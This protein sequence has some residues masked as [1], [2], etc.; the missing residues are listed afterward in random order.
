VS[1]PLGIEKPVLA[2]GLGLERLAMLR[3]DL[4]DIRVFYQCDIDWLRSLVL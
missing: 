3:L 4:E 1:R 2:W